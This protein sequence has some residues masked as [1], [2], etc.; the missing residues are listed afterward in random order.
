M[1]WH[2]YFA[3]E[4]MNLGTS[5]RQTLI[6]VLRRLGPTSSQQPAHLCHLR[7]RLDNQAAI[8]EAAFDEANL[9]VDAFKARLGAIFGVE[10]DTIDHEIIQRTFD[11][12]PTP[13][14]TFSRNGTDYM[15]MALFG[16]PGATW[17]QSGDECRAYLAEHREDWEPA[18][19]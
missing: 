5:A 10:P 15:R 8:F 17:N 19:E 13:I 9:T 16:G 1:T 7:T 4:N 18:E 11:S 12:R 3:I 6:E 2:G 14:A